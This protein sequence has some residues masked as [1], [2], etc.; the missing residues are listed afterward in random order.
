MRGR[1]RRCWSRLASG[2]MDGAGGRWARTGFRREGRE[3]G[4]QVTRKARRGRTAGIGRLA[5]WHGEGGAITGI[6][7]GDGWGRMGKVVTYSVPLGAEALYYAYM[8]KRHADG[9]ARQ[10]GHTVHI[11]YIDVD[12]YSTYICIYITIVYSVRTCVHT[13]YI[14]PYTYRIYWIY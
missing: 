14:V 4:T 10:E 8:R 3:V 2:R 13:A 7:Y 1:R 5:C 9:L 6:G 12:A 11:R